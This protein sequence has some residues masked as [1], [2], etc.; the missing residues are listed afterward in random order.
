MATQT[1]INQTKMQA[2]FHKVA[3]DLS[4]MV[5]SLLCI[6]GDRL[7]LFKDLVA[8]GP[9]TSAELAARTYFNELHV[10]VWLNTLAS[11][12]YLAY[13]SASRRFS[14]PLEH[15]P[16]LAH[17]G[18]P[19]FLGSL[20]QQM[21]ALVQ[22]LD[23]PT[24]AF[25][26]GAGGPRAAYD[27]AWWKGIARFTTAWVGQLLVQ[28]WL[29]AVPEVQARL[30]R[31][32]R[33]ADIGCGHGWV[34][35]TLAQ[36]FPNSYYVG[37]D[38]FEPLI[39]CARANAEAAGV[40]E[41][42]RFRSL[43]ITEGLPEPYDLITTFAVAPALGNRRET[44]RAIHR[45]LRPDGMYLML[46]SHGPDMLEGHTR[47]LRVMFCGFHMLYCLTASGVQDNESLGIMDVP[48]SE[49]WQLCTEVGFSSVHR[50]PLENPLYIL[51]E[52]KP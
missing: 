41:R 7:G 9:A 44:L 50:L 1:P 36:A 37:Y 51:Y 33:V 6:L 48:E 24:Q 46:G 35:I 39:A 20:Y 30:A 34:L 19:T 21:P 8:H 52:I 38:T 42:V 28:Q 14:L 29:P 47:P 16:A 2:F 23:Q 49:V 43:D 40:A 45:G 5:L 32:T 15:A 13:D 11:V 25:R 17:E 4:G 26:Q 12:G 22:L 3:E 27:E 31:G 18:A 10:R